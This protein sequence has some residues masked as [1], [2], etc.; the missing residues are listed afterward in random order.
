MGETRRFSDVSTGYT[1]FENGDLLVAKITPCFENNKIGQARLSHAVG[2]G[3]SEFHVVR[4]NRKLVDDRY[5]LHFLRQDRVRIDGERRMT[6]SGGQRR[7]PPAFLRDLEV[8]LMPL[9]EQRRIAAILDRADA[10]RAKRRQA[11]LLL[12]DVPQAI[13]YDMFG[14]P[15]KANQTIAF[16]DVA[17]LTG[18][19]NLVADDMNAKSA[20][21]VLKISAVT[22]GTFGAAESKP[23]PEGYVPP[24]AHLVKRGDLL[25]SRANTTELVGAVAFVDETPQN[26]ALPDKV[27]RFEWRDPQSVPVYFHTLFRTA[28]MRRRIS[29]LSSATGV[30]EEHLQGQV[31]GDASAAGVDL[32]AA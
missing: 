8:P 4:P 22:S 15:D 13:Y 32:Q 19:R 21:R 7:V 18:G 6:G 2:V 14:D 11:L 20:Y 28:A 16:R 17:G 10:L 3:S 25:M 27:W 9:D 30:Y 31:G 29:Q 5:L 1:L 26:L 12:N 24:P 23:L